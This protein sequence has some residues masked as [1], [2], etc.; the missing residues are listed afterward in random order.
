MDRETMRTTDEFVY[1]VLPA[2]DAEELIER[3]FDR[4]V[5]ELY[6]LPF[7]EVLDFLGKISSALSSCPELLDAST[8]SVS[9]DSDRCRHVHQ[10]LLY[11]SRVFA[12]SGCCQG[13]GRQ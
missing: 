8:A 5:D 13:D 2:F 3:D 12:E 4:V 7:E 9:A 6:N 1:Q 10:F 11:Q